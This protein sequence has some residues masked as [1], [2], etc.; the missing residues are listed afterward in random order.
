MP[1]GTTLP[2]LITVTVIIG[3]LLSIVGAPLSRELDHT[4]VREGRDRYS[5]VHETARQLAIAR[6]TLARVELDSVHAIATVSIRNGNAWDTLEVRPL[7]AAHLGFSQ[8]VVTFGPLGLGYGASNTSI[9][10]RRGAAAE[11]LTVSRLGRLR[12]G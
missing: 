12:R 10:F 6:S 2:E 7:G 8:R 3:V 11:T 1:R 4:A 9:I 5:A